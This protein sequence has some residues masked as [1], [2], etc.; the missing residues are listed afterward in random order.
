MAAKM[1]K[2]TGIR[3][4]SRL[5]NCSRSRLPNQRPDWLKIGCWSRERH[6]TYSKLSHSCKEGVAAA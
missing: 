3:A 5:F 1:A 4:K 2:V 6:V